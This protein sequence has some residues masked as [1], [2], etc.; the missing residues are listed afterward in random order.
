MT[1]VF[2]GMGSEYSLR[3]LAAEARRR[4][5]STLEVD[6]YAPGWKASLDQLVPQQFVLITS[7]HPFVDGTF[8]DEV[9][10]VRA[11]IAALP[12]IVAQYQPRRIYYL[13]HDLAEPFKDDEVYALPMFDAL[14]MPN[15]QAWYL[16]Q[17]T[18]VEVVGWI[19]TASDAIVCNCHIAF[20]PSEI[21]HYRHAGAPIFAQAFEPVLRMRPMV[22]FPAFP[23]LQPLLECVKAYDCEVLPPETSSTAVI[24]SADLVVS[25]G[26]SSVVA[27][28]ARMGRSTLCIADGVHPL[29]AQH[30]RFGAHQKVSIVTPDSVGQWLA[31]HTGTFGEEEAPASD[32]IRRFDFDTA[33]RILLT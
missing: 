31:D 20:L 4:G 13:P 6:M 9:F 22:K 32:G 14:L 8:H 28:A 27:E 15:E 7:S 1:L 16:R 17:Y 25:N 18:R 19:G 23:G 24:R 3:P 12:S 29:A 5:L 10:G 11:E 2:L 26:L 33:F 21:A 30:Q